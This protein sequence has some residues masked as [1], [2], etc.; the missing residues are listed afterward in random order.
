MVFCPFIWDGRLR[1]ADAIDGIEFHDAQCGGAVV[2]DYTLDGAGAG[3]GD[4][5]REV[6]QAAV[7]QEQAAEQVRL[8]YVALTRAVYRCYL[9]AGIYHARRSTREACA[10]MLNWLVAGAAHPF[11][12]WVRGDTEPQ[13]ILDAWHALDGDAIV[14]GALPNVSVPPQRVPS[15]THGNAA[16]LA[17]R[18]AAR[19][20]QEMW[21]ITSFSGLIAAGAAR[22]ARIDTDDAQVIVPARPDYDALATAFDILGT[23]PYAVA[24]AALPADDITRFPRGPAAGECLHRAFEL[25]DFT[26][27]ESWPRAA[28]RALRE[29]PPDVA[30][31]DSAQWLAMMTR[32][33]ADT[34]TS[35]I[36]P[37]LRLSDVGIRQRL[38]ELEFVYPVGSFSLPALRTLLRDAGYP[39]PPLDNGA[40]RGYMKGFI[41]LVFRH[42]GRWWIVDWKSNHLGDTPQD[43]GAEPLATAMAQHGYALQ[44]LLY[45][46][47]LH[48]YLRLRLDDYDYE[49]D[50]GGCLYLFVRG[51]RPAWRV[52]GKPA[53]VFADRPSRALVDALDRL[54]QPRADAGVR[55]VM[56]DDA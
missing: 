43:Y 19:T 37:G 50:F 10:G 56:G 33:L 2:I 32:M 1:E 47:A 4:A 31:G 7:R 26:D 24:G 22:H 8:W 9:V 18:D 30:S 14:V 49:R 36:H 3:A 45:T 11:D 34:V 21:R 12:A 15:A 38:T 28:G 13:A 6:A 39:E 41:D 25:A 23:T 48:R 16:P 51:V 20:T 46:V 5:R 29:R 35:E 53:G 27:A 55:S 54:M 42:D 40:L 52:N 17:A 44:Y